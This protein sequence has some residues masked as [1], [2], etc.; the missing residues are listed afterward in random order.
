MK[1]KHEVQ[2]RIV[3]WFDIHGIPWIFRIVDGYG[4]EC[5]RAAS[6]AEA[7]EKMAA[8]LKPVPPLVDVEEQAAD[9]A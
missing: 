6:E 8:L 5:G 4:C 9:A 2:L 7:I 3:P 1:M